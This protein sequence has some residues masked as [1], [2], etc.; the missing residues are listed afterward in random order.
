MSM[1]SS[2]PYVGRIVDFATSR[3][4]LPL[5]V[6]GGIV[7]FYEGVPIGPLRDIPYAGP[8]LAGLVDGRVDR[9]YARGQLA[10]R[11]IWQEQ[12]RKALAQQAVKAK[13]QQD[14]IDAAAQEYADAQHN[15]AIR[16]ATLEQAIRDQKDEDL[17]PPDPKT[18]PTCR[19]SGIPARVSIGIDAI[20]R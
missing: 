16:I 5:I 3:Y 15:D 13:A 17:G 18:G 7:F 11:L 20:G 10:E 8:A 9:E 1:I 19:R 2:I 6:A 12:Q 14:E 4:G